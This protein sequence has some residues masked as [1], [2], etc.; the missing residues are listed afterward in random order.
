MLA[1][2]LLTFLI[3]TFGTR[4]GADPGAHIAHHYGSGRRLD[5]LDS[6]NFALLNTQEHSSSTTMTKPDPEAETAAAALL[7]RD[8]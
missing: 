6:H 4:S 1:Q 2:F 8:R 5:H 7:S 3:G